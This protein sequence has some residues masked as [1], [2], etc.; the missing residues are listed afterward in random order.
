MRIAAKLLYCHAFYEMYF[1]YEKKLTFSVY[2][3]KRHLKKNCHQSFLA[4]NFNLKSGGEIE[5]FHRH[6]IAFLSRVA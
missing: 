3:R 5:I 2:M 1:L 4:I 6:H